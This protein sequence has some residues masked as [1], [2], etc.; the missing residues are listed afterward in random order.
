MSIPI[1][2]LEA[3]HTA[4]GSIGKTTVVLS[5]ALDQ[6]DLRRARAALAIALDPQGNGARVAWQNPLSG[7]H[8]AFAAAAPPFAEHDRVCRA[9]TGDAAPG[10][11]TASKLTGSACRDS[12][13]TWQIRSGADI[14]A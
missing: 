10:G 6:E 7:A 9:F 8:G 2:G 11:S 1:G 4:T 3:D 13:G 12:D 14:K 5:P